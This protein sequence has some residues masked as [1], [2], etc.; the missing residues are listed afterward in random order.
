MNWK[1][2]LNDFLYPNIKWV[3]GNFF[4]ALALLVLVHYC[5]PD[6]FIA[7]FLSL[8]YAAYGLTLLC[9]SLPQV[10]SEVFTL[11]NKNKYLAIFLNDLHVRTFV[12][13]YFN[14][15]S[16]TLLGCLNILQGVVNQSNWMIALAC[17]YFV[18]TITRFYLLTYVNR[19]DEQKKRKPGEVILSDFR[20]YRTTGVFL[21]LLIVPLIWILVQMIEEHQAYSYNG[22]MFYVMAVFN[23]YIWGMTI[24]GHMMYR[25]IDNPVLTSTRAVAFACALVS[26]LAFETAWF[27]NE[28]A[29]GI[30]AYRDIIIALTGTVSLLIIF[31]IGVRMVARAHTII[32]MN[33]VPRRFRE[34]VDKKSLRAEKRA[35]YAAQKAVYEQYITSILEPDEFKRMTLDKSLFEQK[36]RGWHEEHQEEAPLPEP[37]LEA[38]QSQN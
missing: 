24:F 8:V 37:V 16:T 22:F 30:H 5:L 33:T 29:T 36:K 9:F 21:L 25:K 4:A 7:L 28:A 31:C 1:E 11:L 18:L 17:Y 2:K 35:S 10:V 15:M 12:T 3:Y 32:S 38:S 26:L 34:K 20:K 6:S 14:I 27:R 13:L 23:L 19:S